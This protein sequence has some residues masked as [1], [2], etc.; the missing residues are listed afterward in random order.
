M[1]DKDEKRILGW[2][3]YLFAFIQL[4]P[5]A[6]LIAGEGEESTNFL[7]GLMYFPVVIIWHAQDSSPLY[8][9][10][11]WIGGTLLYAWVGAMAGLALCGLRR[12]H[13]WANDEKW[14]QRIK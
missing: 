1:L 13:R 2:T 5:L 8:K 10:Y 11:L 3:A 12:L 9:A 6:C 7:L 14:D 4:V